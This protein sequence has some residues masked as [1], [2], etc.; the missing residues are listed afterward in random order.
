MSAG[1]LRAVWYKMI[2]RIDAIDI[3][4]LDDNCTRLDDY[5]IMEAFDGFSS[6]CLMLWRV[7]RVNDDT[8]AV[9]RLAAMSLCRMSRRNAQL[10][11]KTSKT[12]FWWSR[13]GT[14]HAERNSTKLETHCWVN[15]K[16]QSSAQLIKQSI[17]R[18]DSSPRSHDDL[19][20]SHA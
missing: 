20:A 17:F 9:T 19:R 10:H 7:R 5:Y 11:V 13:E 1:T 16:A 18:F 8:T 3:S 12:S 6:V 14:Q 15:H 2:G 4:Q